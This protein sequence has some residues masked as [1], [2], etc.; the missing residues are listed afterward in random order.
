MNKFRWAYIGAG[1]IAY[2]T[3]R[4][5]LKG[6]HEITAVYNRTYKK[7]VAFAEKF[8]AKAYESFDE[9]L[10]SGGFDGVYICTPHTSHV[11]YAVSALKAHFPV[12][13][14]KPVTMNSDE[15]REIME[16]VK[17]TGKVFSAVLEDA[18]VYKNTESGK[19][20]FLKFVDYVN[21]Q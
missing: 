11:E 10:S 14:E 3:A 16:V 19:A 12:L 21:A 4:S 20:A 5:I 1:N 15:L 2:S 7:A 13:C 18:G 6:D 8:G 17:E 9:L